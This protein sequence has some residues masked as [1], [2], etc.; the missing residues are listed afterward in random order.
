[1]IEIDAENL[2]WVA[3]FV[4][5]LALLALRAY[6]LK[7]RADRH[8][9]HD[10]IVA[11]TAPAQRAD[12]AEALATL[13]AAESEHSAAAGAVAKVRAAARHKSPPD[14]SG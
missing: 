11:K 3:V 1:M 7:L 14:D 4:L 10:D 13:E 6:R 8:R 9:H 2:P 5:L 12:V